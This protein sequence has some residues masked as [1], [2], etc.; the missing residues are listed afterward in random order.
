MERY[1]E[2][3]KKNWMKVVVVLSA[4]CVVI[5]GIVLIVR[6]VNRGGSEDEKKFDGFATVLF[7]DGLEDLSEG[8]KVEVGDKL[9][10][11]A[12]IRFDEGL[13]GYSLLVNFYEPATNSFVF[14][15]P[16]GTILKYDVGID[17]DDVIMVDKVWDSSIEEAIPS[18]EIDELVIGE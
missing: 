11:D 16:D 17:V 6:A 14:T 9:L 5:I 1:I 12:E 10:S 15:K 8:W 2:V 7:I 3:L 18:M 13:N 4:V